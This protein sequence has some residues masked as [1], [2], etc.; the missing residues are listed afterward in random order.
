[1]LPL[2]L[3]NLLCVM[4]VKQLGWPL[5]VLT[6][7]SVVLVH[8]SGTVLGAVARFGDEPEAESREA[9]AGH[10]GRRDLCQLS[11]IRRSDADCRIR[12][13]LGR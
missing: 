8:R 3:L 6:G 2:A 4:V 7:T 9:A 12:G 11:S 5:L 10:P 1:M 13:D